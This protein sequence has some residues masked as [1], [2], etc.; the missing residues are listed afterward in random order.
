MERR[1]GPIPNARDETMFDRIDM[2]VVDVTLEVAFVANGM[3][4]V[5]ALPYAALALGRAAAGNPFASRQVVREYRFDQPPARGKIG[6]A[7]G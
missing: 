2:D 5:P 7:F 3:F 6:V 1:K 4:P